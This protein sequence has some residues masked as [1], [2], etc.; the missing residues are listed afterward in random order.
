MRRNFEREF[1]SLDELGDIT[2]LSTA[3]IRNLIWEGRIK[4]VRFGR[5]LRVTKAE[6]N[7]IREEGIVSYSEAP[8][9][10]PPRKRAAGHTA[11]AELA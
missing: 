7:R 2:G 3:H 4:A 10:H 9:K 6:L 8:R 5:V 11:A 1:F